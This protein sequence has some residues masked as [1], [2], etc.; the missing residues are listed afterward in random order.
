MSAARWPDN[1]KLIKVIRKVL[2][3]YYS[4]WKSWTI[5]GCQLVTVK[6]GKEWYWG[7]QYLVLR[8][9]E[10]DPGALLAIQRNED[11]WKAKCQRLR[12]YDQWVLNQDH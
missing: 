4:L 12:W 11:S 10:T 2:E 5:K 7:I 9:E 6:E 3:L 1:V 8:E